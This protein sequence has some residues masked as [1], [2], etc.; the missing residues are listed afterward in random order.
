METHA[1]K[2]RKGQQHGHHE[3]LEQ[4]SRVGEDIFLS[5]EQQV[6]AAAAAAAHTLTHTHTSDIIHVHVTRARETPV[7]C[8]PANV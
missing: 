4:L 3:L 1:N 5:E 7:A 2:P 6:P 8:Q